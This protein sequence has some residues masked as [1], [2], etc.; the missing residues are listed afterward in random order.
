MF[1]P[2]AISIIFG[3]T[4]ATV[5]TLFLV[6]VLYGLFFTVDFSKTK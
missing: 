6:P 4:F 5:I 3:L 1:R 2:E